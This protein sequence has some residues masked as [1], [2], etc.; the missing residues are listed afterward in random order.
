MQ[1]FF[2]KRHFQAGKVNLRDLLF[3]EKS[4]LTTSYLYVI[5]NV[6]TLGKTN[7]MEAK[8]GDSFPPF[9]TACIRIS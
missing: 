3:N 1:Y 6:L 7:Q 5:H 4:R 8:R 9:F 2:R